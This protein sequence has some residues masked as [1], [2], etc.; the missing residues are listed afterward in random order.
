MRRRKAKAW[1]L[2]LPGYFYALGPFRFEQ[3]ITERAAREDMRHWLKVARLP[4][5]AQVWTA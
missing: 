4:R 1:Y 3:A 2:K 5:G